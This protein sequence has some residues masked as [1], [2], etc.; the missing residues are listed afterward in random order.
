MKSGA[1]KWTIISNGLAE[2]LGP[3]EAREEQ[4]DYRSAVWWNAYSANGNA[5]GQIVYANYG[6]IEDYNILEKVCSLV[7]VFMVMEFN[8]RLVLKFNEVT[9]KTEYKKGNL[10][11]YTDTALLSLKCEKRLNFL[12]ECI[13]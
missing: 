3:K 1:D 4:N 2:P 5:T 11:Y 13:K 12:L 8:L 7:H 10:L 9:T 6:T